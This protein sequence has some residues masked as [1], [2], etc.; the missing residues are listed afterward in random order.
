MFPS[1]NLYNVIPCYDRI[2][3]YE[4]GNVIT[5][6]RPD[7]SIAVG[8]IGTDGIVLATDSKRTEHEYSEI[9]QKLWALT[10]NI[11]LMSLGWNSGYR[12]FLIDLYKERIAPSNITNSYLEIVEQFSSAVRGNFD[13]H[14]T[15]DAINLLKG[16][17]LSLDF[18]LAG[19]D[20]EHN[21]RIF[22]VES[23]SAIPFAPTEHRPYYFGGVQYIGIYWAKKIG[24]AS[25]LSNHKL[26]CEFLKKFAVMAIL[27]TIIFS[28]M[29]C[30][31]IQLATVDKDGYHDN[32][33]EVEI[34]KASLD[35][36]QQWLYDYLEDTKKRL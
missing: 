13:L 31:P 12:H 4:V 8:L 24:L 27:E 30:E 2:S 26:S 1:Q 34:I 19:Y 29:V 36:K 6:E 9:T 15:E 22:A 28:D 20:L 33:K 32:N 18:V 21:P 5:G 7:M 25:R 14:R 16:A 11:G 3:P 23:M 35:S 17:N 10:P